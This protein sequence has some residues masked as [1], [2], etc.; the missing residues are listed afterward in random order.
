MC[1]P[2][3]AG[4]GISVRLLDGMVFADQMLKR[5]APKGKQSRT[6][7]PP[8]KTWAKQGGAVAGVGFISQGDLRRKGGRAG[9]G[10]SC[11]SPCL[12]VSIAPP[13][14]RM[15]VPICCRA[16]SH[17]LHWHMHL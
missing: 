13:H 3:Q 1:P 16:H 2:S 7:I 14:T 11:A 10:L 12:W 15:C 17:V 8:L 9:G 6:Q 4:A 5:L